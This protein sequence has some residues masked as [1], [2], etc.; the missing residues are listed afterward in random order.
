MPNLLTGLT[1]CSSK[2]RIEFQAFVETTG[3][4]L[5]IIKITNFLSIPR[6]DSDGRGG[7]GSGVSYP[8]DMPPVSGTL[9]YVI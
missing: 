9:F 2:L 8:L 6:N 1:E 4:N 3:K 5:E 7:S